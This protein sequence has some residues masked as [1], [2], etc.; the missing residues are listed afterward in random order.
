MDNPNT[1]KNRHGKGAIQIYSIN[2]SLSKRARE[3][4]QK[5][6]NLKCAPWE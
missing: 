2:P 6:V 4:L 3:R 5:D 1:G